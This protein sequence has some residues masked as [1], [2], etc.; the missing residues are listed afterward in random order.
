MLKRRSPRSVIRP[1]NS[2][3]SGSAHSSMSSP[4]ASLNQDE[5]TTWPLSSSSPSRFFRVKDRPV[6]STTQRAS[7]VFVS[8]PSVN[9]IRCRSPGSSA[10]KPPGPNRS[11]PVIWWRSPAISTS[12]TRQPSNRSFPTSQFLSA[13]WFSKR[14]RSSW[15]VGSAAFL[16]GPYSARR[17]MSELSPAGNQKRT[18]NF[19]SSSASMWSSRPHTRAR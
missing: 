6:A 12:W 4:P 3:S 13:R 1:K 8:S 18:P 7:I 17:L 15:Y 5:L 2:S 16:G 14:P 10:S 19:G 11:V 9:V